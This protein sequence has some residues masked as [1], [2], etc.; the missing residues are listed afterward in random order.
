MS[1]PDADSPRDNQVREG[2]LPA[3]AEVEIP[4]SIPA[5]VRV[6]WEIAS[7]VHPFE[8]AQAGMLF[9]LHKTSD[10][11]DILEGQIP[12]EALAEMR[13]A[14]AEDPET[15]AALPFN[16]PDD[17]TDFLTQLGQIVWSDDIAG[18]ALCYETTV[19]LT[20]EEI[21][22]APEDP[23]QRQAYLEECAEGKEKSRFVVAATRTDTWSVVH[24]RFDTDPEFMEQAPALAPDLLK[25]MTRYQDGEPAAD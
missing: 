12:D 8:D 20:D 16:L 6:T 24:P 22:G 15:L 7:Q 1:T 4:A 17:G 10:L 23:E 5:I 11:A 9:T 14:A 21:A 3:D 18:V 25:L 19:M 2:D 13:H